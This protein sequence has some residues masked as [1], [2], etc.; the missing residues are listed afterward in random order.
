MPIGNA[1][2]TGNIIAFIEQHHLNNKKLNVLDIGCGIGHN[3]FIFREMFEIRYCRLKPKDWM[4]RVEAIE[5]F[6]NYRNPVWDYVYDKVIVSDCLKAI[7]LLDKKYDIIFTTEVLEHFQKKQLYSL[8][9]KLIEK[10]TDDGSIIITIPLGEEKAILE[11]KELF[12][13]IY[14]IHQTYLTIKDFER[15][16]I[17]H[18]INDGIFMIGKK[19]E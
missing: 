4:H 9:D 16:N 17:K 19:G 14:E 18:K 11:Q 8:L 1:Y 15:Y 6:E 7:S 3:G 5:V 2:A 10:L 13:N 12:G